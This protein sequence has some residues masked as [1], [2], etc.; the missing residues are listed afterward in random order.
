M[1][2]L[3]RP[4]FA[5]K[6][7][8]ICLIIFNIVGLLGGNK[9]YWGIIDFSQVFQ[10]SL[11]ASIFLGRF[12]GSHLFIILGILMIRSYNKWKEL[13]RQYEIYEMTKMYEMK[14]DN[15]DKLTDIAN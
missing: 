2:H 7:G 12:L 6:V 10:G 9:S 8:G 3:K 14:N 15:D 5:S 1:N 13:Q 4:F 11:Q